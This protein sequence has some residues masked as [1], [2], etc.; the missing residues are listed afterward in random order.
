MCLGMLPVSN[1][2][3]EIEP[4]VSCHC[5]GCLPFQLFGRLPATVWQAHFIINIK[6]A[7]EMNMTVPF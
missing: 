2:A 5:Q 1:G 4:S 6:L 7:G 3:E